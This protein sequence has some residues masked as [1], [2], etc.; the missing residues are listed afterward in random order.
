MGTVHN[1]E[2]QY[3]RGI[4]RVDNISISLIKYL[5]LQQKADDEFIIDRT[6]PF[7]SNQNYVIIDVSSLFIYIVI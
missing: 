5:Y 1:L 2:G 6:G 7:K 4:D 3:I